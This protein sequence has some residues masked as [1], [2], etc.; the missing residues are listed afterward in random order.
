MHILKNKIKR[1]DIA[2]NYQT[3][4]KTMTKAVVD[5]RRNVM[6]LD[7]ELH[8]DIEA[9]LLED[10]SLQDDLWGINIYPSMPKED[11]IEYTSMINIRPHQGNNS[12]E[13]EDKTIKD[14]IREIVFGFIDYEG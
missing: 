12:M 14:K 13:V 9:A 3:Y 11:F 5:V 10:G 8:S 7:G 4:F 1:S 6:G 2:K